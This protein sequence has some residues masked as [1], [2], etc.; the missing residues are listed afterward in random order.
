MKNSLIRMLVFCVAGVFAVS[1]PAQDTAEEPAQKPA[2]QTEI[3]SAALLQKT[4]DSYN[5]EGRRDPFRDLLAGRDVKA[6]GQ[7]GLAAMSVDD[8]VLIGITKFKGKFTA[9]INGSDGFP[10]K[11]SV[12]NRFEDGF[13][14]SINDSKVVFRK[15]KERGIQMFRPKDVTKEINP[16]E[17]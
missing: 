5:P 4:A 12:G 9:I 2:G 10:V 6:T 8:V 13:V 11:I 7:G 16:E 3:S 17:R 14:L 15:T 1:A